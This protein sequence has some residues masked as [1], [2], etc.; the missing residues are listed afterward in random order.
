MSPGPETAP[1]LGTREETR[2]VQ[3]FLTLESR[4]EIRPQIV[5]IHHQ[6]VELRMRR[7]PAA[8]GGREVL[9]SVAVAGIRSQRA[10]FAHKILGRERVAVLDEP[11]LNVGLAGELLVERRGLDTRLAGDFADTEVL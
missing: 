8:V 7:S 9:D 4:C 11:R 6:A 2:V 10:T 5:V 3:S 1:D